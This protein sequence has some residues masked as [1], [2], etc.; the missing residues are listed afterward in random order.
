MRPHSSSLARSLFASYLLILLLAGLADAQTAQ[1]MP[2]QPR[3]TRAVDEAQLATLKGNTHPLARAQF[4]RGAAAPTLALARML[5]VLK[6]SPEQEAALI[7]LL[8]QQQD[9]SSPNY[10]KWLTPEEFGKRFGPADADLQTVTGW[11]QGHGF[12]VTQIS[13]GRTVIEFS[14]T[15]AMVEEAFHTQIH[16]YVVKGESHWANASDPQIPD[17]LIPV[18]AGVWTMHNFLKQPQVHLARIAWKPKSDPALFERSSL[19]ATDSTPWF[20]PIT[21]PSTTSCRASGPP[22]ASG[23]WPEATSTRRTSRTFTIGRLTRRHNRR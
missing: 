2:V 16:R 3:I 13:K 1:F 10:H 9:K 15:A 5:L 21:T 14:G 18:V 7:T 8:D 23:S 20:L 6:R 4:D 22:A 17:A 12:Q 19:P 11:L